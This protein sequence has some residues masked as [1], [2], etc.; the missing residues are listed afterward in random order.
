MTAL[1]RKYRPKTMQD[2]L[3][4]DTLMRVLGAAIE[5]KRLSQAYILTGIRG[6]GKTT[7]ARIIARSLNCENGPTLTPC[8]T[9]GS[10]QA[11]DSDSSMDVIEVDAAS[12]NG[13]DHIREI[14]SNVSYAPMT[15]GGRK[16]YIIDEAHMLSNASWNGL[17]KTLEEPPE[18]VMFIFAT[19]EERKIP[20][21]ISSRCQTLRLGRIDVEHITNNIE[22]ICTAENVS[23]ED[24]A[25]DLIARAA[26]GSMRDGLS[27]LDQAISAEPKG[28]TTE[29]VMKML[30]RAGRLDVGQLTI[31][32]A[33]G[34]IEAV[35]SGWQDFMKAGYEPVQLLEDVAT[36]IHQAHMTIVAPSYLTAL[37]FPEA[38]YK[39]VD[40][41][42]KQAPGGAFQGC[43]HY[44]LDAITI[45]N[46][47]PSPA[48]AV[49]MAL[50]RATA[51]F[52][53]LNKK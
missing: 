14:I 1:A 47:A 35:L 25:K 23:I 43:G 38:E 19:T 12:N 24:T 46:S 48:L 17:L 34:D 36:W 49:E 30:G 2:L 32:V 45:A 40:T 37:G 11:M 29:A 3:G 33:Q 39:M 5:H 51:K 9:C 26:G 16:I 15:P 41:L 8:G 22:K 10:C 52:A 18:H 13:I 20:A 53:S 27:I 21:T 28:V 31:K 42:S 7:T 6:V 50:V 4:Q 44:L